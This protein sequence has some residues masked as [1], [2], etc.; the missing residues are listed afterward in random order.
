MKRLFNFN[1][2]AAAIGASVGLAIGLSGMAIAF[3]T[4]GGTGSG[5]AT[6][7]V[8]TS[9]LTIDAN[10]DSSTPL[11]LAGD[12]QPVDLT[13]TNGNPYTV[14][15]YGDTATID[16]GSIYCGAT[17]VP[18]SW[19]TLSSGTITNTSVTPAD[20]T[21]HAQTGHSGLTLKM[22]DV[23]ADQDACQGAAITF[24]VTVA[25]ETGN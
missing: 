25:S 11:I 6:G 13:V 9:N 18:D 14:D 23:N 7:G 5:S 12:A 20:N 15:L 24:N 2:K 4:T 10:V 17:N 3:W 1:K 16:T 19:F 21:A 22:N 8:P